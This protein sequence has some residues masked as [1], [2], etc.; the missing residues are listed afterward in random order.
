MA[1]RTSG[2]P[3]FFDSLRNDDRSGT[4]PLSKKIQDDSPELPSFPD[5]SRNLLCGSRPTRHG[6]SRQA[7]FIVELL[8]KHTPG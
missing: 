4:W 8:Y 5:D 6:N 7:E 1:S 3:A 2:Q